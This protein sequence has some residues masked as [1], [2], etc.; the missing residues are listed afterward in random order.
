ML[1]DIQ[2]MY[3]RIGAIEI[4]ENDFNGEVTIID[5]KGDIL[6]S[7]IGNDSEVN[8][9][10]NSNDEAI[11]VEANNVL[12]LTTKELDV[13]KSIAW[14]WAEFETNRKDSYMGADDDLKAIIKILHIPY[15]YDLINEEQYQAYV[16]SVEQFLEWD[17]DFFNNGDY[18]YEELDDFVE[19]LNPLYKKFWW[20]DIYENILW[21]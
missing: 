20:S 17:G 6:V 21:N 12:I 14:A 5:T 2:G 1:I 8:Y 3:S 10:L 16:K 9:L 7:N 13:V 4:H 15:I 11:E 18:T 19:Q